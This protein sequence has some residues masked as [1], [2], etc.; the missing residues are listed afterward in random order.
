MLSKWEK[1]IVLFSYRETL[2][3]SL[4]LFYVKIFSFHSNEN[5]Y[6]IRL[7]FRYNDQINF[8]IVY[9]AARMGKAGLAPDLEKMTDVKP[10][11]EAILTHIPA[12]TSTPKTSNAAKS[13]LCFI[14]SV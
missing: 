4:S 11:F 5:R 3:L 12:P 7:K 13:V 9:A 10:L 8:P 6:P 2:P 14:L 1:E